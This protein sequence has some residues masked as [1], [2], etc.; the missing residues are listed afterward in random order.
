MEKRALNYRVIIEPD[1]RTGT[2]EPIYTAYVPTLGIATDGDTMEEALDNAE[3][4]ILA[5]VES[6]REDG[7][8]IPIDHVDRY[9]VANTTINVQ[10]WRDCRRFCQKI[11]VKF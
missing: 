1:E 5:Y 10:L 3:E 2:N 9:I 4:A 6:L 11:S 8:E 7:L